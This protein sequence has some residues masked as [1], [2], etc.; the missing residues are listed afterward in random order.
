[1][2]KS[3]IA[4]CIVAMLILYGCPVL[5][6]NSIDNGSYA[7]PSWLAGTWKEVKSTGKG[8][9]FFIESKKNEKGNL[10]VYTLDSLGNRHDIDRRAVILSDI[11]GEVFL[12]AYDPGYDLADPGW[13]LYKFQQV[14]N[15]EF[16]LL[17]LK[18][19][20]I[21]YSAKQEDIKAFIEKNKDNPE[22][23]E[24]SERSRYLKQK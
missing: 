1:M 8:E 23:Y 16:M 7:V 12:S 4:I 21:E 18:E 9:S 14:S 22:I 3:I 15:T 20:T 10:W 13:Y 19:K 11:G 24:E 6:V 2:K 5:T 17:P